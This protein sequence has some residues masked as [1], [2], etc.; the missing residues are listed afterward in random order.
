MRRAPHVLIRCSLAVLAVLVAACGGSTVQT[1]GYQAADGFDPGRARLDGP[2]LFLP[3][4]VGDGS[5]PL[6]GSG[7]DG[8]EYVVVVERGG[9]RLAL[10]VHQMNYHHLAQGELAGYPYMVSY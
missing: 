5:V 8:G 9:K 1:K 6:K 10:S 4:K 3:F 2:N 7:L